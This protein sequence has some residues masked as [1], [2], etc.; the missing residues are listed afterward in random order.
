MIWLIDEHFKCSSV[1]DK[2]SDFT[3][4][5]FYLASSFISSEK[6]ECVAIKN[7]IIFMNL[8]ICS[9]NPRKH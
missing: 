1:Y 2:S 4:H 8:K 9:L 5:L 6:I 7:A 3:T